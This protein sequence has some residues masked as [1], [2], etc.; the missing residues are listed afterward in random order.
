MSMDFERS[1]HLFLLNLK[2]RILSEVSFLFSAILDRK[3]WLPESE[4]PLASSVFIFL[5]GL[6][7]ASLVLRFLSIVILKSEPDDVRK[8]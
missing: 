8:S 6:E 1:R 2:S 7:V 3:D 5:E 4:E